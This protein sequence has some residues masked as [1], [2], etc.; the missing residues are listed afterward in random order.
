MIPQSVPEYPT[1]KNDFAAQIA[2][3]KPPPMN[4]QLAEALGL[5]RKLPDAPKGKQRP[6]H[7]AGQMNGTESAFA[8][9][10]DLRKQSG[11]VLHYEFEA[12]KFK[13]ADER[14]WFCPDFLVVLASGEIQFVDVKGGAPVEDDALVKVKVAAGK[15]PMFR[16]Y[17][18]TKVK[19][20]GFVWREF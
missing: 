17:F 4:P 7:V 14:C 8:Q 11:E 16:F 5:M 6:R 20:E 10:L 2:A 1:M 19:G 15:Y 12:V 3:H 13:I 18:A 9:E